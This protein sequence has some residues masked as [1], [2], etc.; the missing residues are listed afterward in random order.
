MNRWKKEV[1]KTGKKQL[2]LLLFVCLLLIVPFSVSAKA[3][4]KKFA[5]NQNSILL[6]EG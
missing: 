2:K 3:K 1:G 4:E 5:M 6:Y